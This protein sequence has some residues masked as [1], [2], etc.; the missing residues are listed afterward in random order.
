MFK[1][2]MWIGFVAGLTTLTAFP[3]S[4]QERQL[5]WAEKMFSELK[6]DF[7]VVARGSD[8]RAT[9]IVTNIYEEPVTIAN[10]DTTCGCTAAKPDKTQLNTREQARIEVQMNTTKFMRRKDS[11]VDVTLTFHGP[12]GSATKTVRVPITAYIRSD[13]VL[14]PGNAD[15]GNV[16]FGQGAERK[17]EIAYAGRDDWKIKEVRTGNS[18][19]EAQVREVNRAPG[20]VDYELVVRLPADAP[21]GT[22]QDQITLITDDAN[23]PEVPI[24][25]SG[26]VEPDITVTP[27]TYTLGN[28]KP[29]ETKPFNFVVRG[30]RAFVIEHVQC[31]S[32]DCF[33]VMKPST[34]PKVTHIIPFK[35]TAPNKP[36]QFSEEFTFTIAGRPEPITCRAEGTIV[37]GT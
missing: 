24:L 5:N 33:E 18:R 30:K 21:M 12:Q 15:F 23:A 35:M 11:N 31:D 6:H 26:R 34:E 37:A 2:A 7:G 17:I 25:V 19:I 28:L 22:V 36:G 14:T 32:A 3:V 20:Q 1:H 9:I 10:V 13:V 8:T 27:T 29:G 16:E 4:A